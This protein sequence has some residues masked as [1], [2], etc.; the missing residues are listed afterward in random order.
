MF[1]L[2]EFLNG[3][4]SILL[5]SASDVAELNLFLQRIG[6]ED[7]CMK[8]G[9]EGMFHFSSHIHMDHF[10][11]WIGEDK[12]NVFH[13]VIQVFVLGVESGKILVI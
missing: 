8:M 9:E 2:D 11:F 12:A 1:S 6:K 4:I 5:G 13:T 7:T 3:N 10:R